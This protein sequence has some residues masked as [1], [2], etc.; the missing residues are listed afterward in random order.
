MNFSPVQQVGAAG[1]IALQNMEGLLGKDMREPRKLRC[2]R[3]YHWLTGTR[4]PL[5]AGIALFSSSL[6][7]GR[8]RAGELALALLAPFALARASR[9]AHSRR[10]IALARASRGRLLASTPALALAHRA[11][12]GRHRLAPR[13][14]ALL[15]AP[16]AFSIA[17]RCGRTP[18]ALI[19]PGWRSRPRHHR[20]P[21]V[22]P[23]EV[24]E[25][26]L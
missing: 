2:W 25:L 11:R 1:D 16:Q 20:L 19:A 26:L 22:L 9:I 10:Y 3:S 7:Y 17:R 21:R 23:P 5:G 24:E 8:S 18:V 15:F 4:L 13:G 12:G 14:R 6:A